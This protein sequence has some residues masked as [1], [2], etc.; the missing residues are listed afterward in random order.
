MFVLHTSNRAENLLEHLTKILETPQPSVF[1]KEVFLIQSQGME[2]WLSQ[3]LAERSQLWANFEY[4][5]P[6]RFFNEMT[7]K[8]G[9]SLQ[10]QAFG[11]ENMLWQFESILRTIDADVYKPI[12]Q[13]LT[14]VSVERKRYQLAQQLAYLY[15][16]YQFMRPDWLATWE[17]NEKVELQNPSDIT[18]RT[19]LWQAE[20]WRELIGRQD[21]E[22]ISHHGERW[23]DAI[24]ELETRRRGDLEKILPA[25]ISVLG[26][27]TLSPMYLAYLQALSKHIQVH[28][29]L[30]NPCE[31]FWAESNTAVKHQ[32]RL[33]SIQAGQ[34][35]GVDEAPINPLLGMLGQQGRDFQVLLL[36]QEANEIEITSFDAV[37]STGEPSL[38]EQLQNDILFN[39]AGDTSFQLQDDD[40]S[41]SIHACHSRLREVEVL[42]D[43]L[44]ASFDKHPDLDLR[45]VV[46]MAPDI[47][48][49]LP[50]IDAT[51][52]DI[53]Y[54]VADRSLR[55]SNLLLDILLR[56]FDLS[57]SR[58]LWNEVLAVLEEPA[59]REQFGL[60]DDDI[61]MV[62]HWV[63][64]TR[65][66]WGESAEHRKDIGVGEF[67]ENSWQAGLERLLMGYAVPSDAE[68]CDDILPY[69]D[70]EGSQAQALGGFYSYFKLLKTARAELSKDRTLK[71]WVEKLIGFA[72]QLILQDSETE[73][74]WGQLREM[75]EQLTEVAEEHTETLTLQVLIDY[76][77]STASESKTATGFMRGQLTFCSM[78]PMRA[79]PFSV[80]G[81]LGMNEGEFPNIDGRAAFDLMDSEFRRGD[82]SRR[83]DERY[84][85]LETLVSSRKQ[86]LISYIGQS[87]KTNDEIPPS[88]VVSELLDVL[89]HYYQ[90]APETVVT[91]HPLQAFSPR[92]FVPQDDPRVKL[93][94]YSKTAADVA[95][96][97]Q[98][99]TKPDTE[100]WWKGEL[101]NRE[102]LELAADSKMVIDLQ[103]LFRFYN[104]PQRYFV[105]KHL[106]LRIQ[107]PEELAGTSESFELDNL[108]KFFVNQEWLAR[109][110]SEDGEA[111]GHA[112]LKRLRAEG[113]WPHGVL[114]DQLFD[115]MSG[116]LSGFVEKLREL[117]I[118]NKHE[119][120]L[121][122][123]TLG[124]YRL[125]GALSNVYD[126]GNLLY[127]YA[128]CKP[129]D[130]MT[131][132]LNHLIGLNAP[133][134]EANTTYMMHMDGYWKFDEVADSESRL[135]ALLDAYKTAQSGLSPLLLE[136]AFAWVTRELN[137]KSRSK[138]TPQD[139]A[140]ATLET[141]YGQ[142]SYW[143]LLYRGG[144]VSELLEAEAFKHLTESLVKPLLTSRSGI[145]DT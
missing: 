78:L 36:E 98:S 101:Q 107:R 117:N 65:I 16:Q 97:L 87:I 125:K 9:L 129:K 8:L 62:R 17:K 58:M 44:L 121:V 28:F 96:R 47:Q 63:E 99:N 103:D 124:D 132:W 60:F 76:L 86:I 24:T 145:N 5:F 94:S 111:V 126:N 80:I 93:F 13:Y 106:Q 11:R 119:P 54:A 137:A 90:I 127:R 72:E 74:Q 61:L 12:N 43:Q 39:E 66:R 48:T 33:Q 79:I 82:R 41:L 133:E 20:L 71:E 83:A 2:R 34:I 92:Y 56:F 138:K 114:G 113:R 95:M 104:H 77:E 18:D 102:P 55:Q 26:I 140:L 59:V 122:D 144:D 32:L 21:G 50:Y 135:L 85:F 57:Q 19:Q 25:R 4:L 108:E 70:I 131:A 139:E 46:V 123:F 81:L 142:D 143:Q 6:A 64:E 116:E 14:G 38:L 1:S 105:E 27:N 120:T 37:K 22:G 136:P 15:D 52:D 7:N 40:Y 10:Q 53:P 100:F 141:T 134:V 110:L 23:K 84:Q 118:G 128:R 45:N 112:F 51:F 75:F 31:A 73:S 49:Y 35:H 130:N 3:Q 109:H 42:K 69:S 115:N 30:L 91:K 67:S 29:Y 89:D 88:V 68:F